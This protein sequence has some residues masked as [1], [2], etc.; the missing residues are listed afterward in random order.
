MAVKT[1]D[2]QKTSEDS[3]KSQLASAYEDGIVG[4]GATPQPTRILEPVFY[5]KSND[6]EDSNNNP[7]YS[8]DQDPEADADLINKTRIQKVASFSLDKDEIARLSEFLDARSFEDFTSKGILH[9]IFYNAITEE[10]T[11]IVDLQVGTD[12]GN[13]AVAV[14]NAIIGEVKTEVKYSK[15][16]LNLLSTFLFQ[17]MLLENSLIKGQFLN[18]INRGIQRELGPFGGSRSFINHGGQIDG[19]VLEDYQYW[20]G[21]IFRYLGGTTGINTATTKDFFKTDLLSLIAGS[22]GGLDGMNDNSLKNALARK[23]ISAWI[24]QCSVAGAIACDFGISLDF[25]NRVF[26]TEDIVDKH[27]SMYTGTTPELIKTITPDPATM[28]KLYSL[29]YMFGGSTPST[30]QNIKAAPV[31]KQANGG[32]NPINTIFDRNYQSVNIYGMMD[33]CDN[34]VYLSTILSRELQLSNGAHRIQRMTQPGAD[35]ARMMLQMGSETNG[36]LRDLHFSGKRLGVHDD[37]GKTIAERIFAFNPEK[38]FP[39]GPTW[40]AAYEFVASDD[41][42]ADIGGNHPDVGL[43]NTL[44]HLDPLNSAPV[45]DGMMTG[46]VKNFYAFE[47]T[48]GLEEKMTSQMRIGSNGTTITS[49][50]K[51]NLDDPF[52][53]GTLLEALKKPYDNL[54][55]AHFRLQQTADALC[56]VPEDIARFDSGDGQHQHEYLGPLDIMK[57]VLN[58]CAEMIQDVGAAGYHTSADPPTGLSKAVQLQALADIVCMTQFYRTQKDVD[59]TPDGSPTPS[60]HRQMRQYILRRFCEYDVMWDAQSRVSEETQGLSDGQSEVEEYYEVTGLKPSIQDQLSSTEKNAVLG[61]DKGF[62]DACNLVFLRWTPTPTGVGTVTFNSNSHTYTAAQYFEY[63]KSRYDDTLNWYDLVRVYPDFIHMGNKQN[64]LSYAP[65]I[66]GKGALVGGDQIFKLFFG[67]YADTL[68]GSIVERVRRVADDIERHMTK[69]YPLETGSSDDILNYGGTT[70]AHGMDR[71]Q[72]FSIILEMFSLVLCDMVETEFIINSSASR[73]QHSPDE[74]WSEDATLEIKRQYWFTSMSSLPD[75]GPNLGFDNPFEQQDDIARAHYVTVRPKIG[76]EPPERNF[77]PQHTG[78]DELYVD[79]SGFPLPSDDTPSDTDDSD[80]GLVPGLSSE[81]DPENFINPAADPYT[82]PHG[83]TALP[84]LTLGELGHYLS[85]INSQ[86]TVSNGSRIFP[87][88]WGGF[89]HGSLG[90]LEFQFSP[91]PFIGSKAEELELGMDEDFKVGGEMSLRTFQELGYKIREQS[92]AMSMSFYPLILMYDYVN[93]ISMLM[94]MQRLNQELRSN[95]VTEKGGYF[96]D[97]LDTFNEDLQ[98]LVE[99][100]GTDS[101]EAV[102][103]RIR[104]FMKTATFHQMDSV[105]E[106]IRDIET[107][108]EPPKVSA[109][110]N[111]HDVRTGIGTYRNNL[112]LDVAT[113]LMLDDMQADLENKEVETGVKESKHDVIFYGFPPDLLD[114]NMRALMASSLNKFYDP[115]VSSILRLRYSKTSE[116]DSSRFF[117][118]EPDQFDYQAINTSYIVTRGAIVRALNVHNS[119]TFDELVEDVKYR[120]VGQMLFGQSNSSGTFWPNIVDLFADGDGYK[121]HNLIEGLIGGL[122]P[123]P[124]EH[125]RNAVKSTLLQYLFERSSRMVGSDIMCSPGYSGKY[126]DKFYVKKIL[127]TVLNR[128]ATNRLILKMPNGGEDVPETFVDAIGVHGV[129]PPDLDD[130]IEAIFEPDTSPGALASSAREPVRLKRDF[131]EF[132]EATKPTIVRSGPVPLLKTPVMNEEMFIVIQALMNSSLASPRTIESEVFAPLMFDHVFAFATS[133]LRD[134][135]NFTEFVVDTNTGGLLSSAL[136]TSEEALEIEAIK[137]V[138]FQDVSLYGES[139]GGAF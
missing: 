22:I 6:P 39:N 25:V 106:K 57:K 78:A 68:S 89:Y 113:K 125:L 71:A 108:L 16:L 99:T 48:S 90:E 58:H 131:Q 70:M 86:Y 54:F 32:M 5:I 8:A 134:V 119:Q 56:H 66:T 28:T 62:I 107:G 122:D 47:S 77:I 29:E 79:P 129:N 37:A 82:G 117:V 94:G 10:N 49:I 85:R 43:M 118:Q 80:P 126:I 59:S 31:S 76:P 27:I 93:S 13:F 104:K 137:A 51:N 35:Q 30:P 92:C 72:L 132:L 128:S 3:V 50:I 7:A 138:F 130:L 4:Q 2:I 15:S 45:V 83:A 33:T 139:Y 17:R 123:I 67:L 69:R 114:S 26:E 100:S 95:S 124:R 74:M 52:E 64:A 9:Q 133:K 23:T 12:G 42:G 88:A 63:T 91:S 103:E 97:F 84:T 53:L 111:E 38:V 135:G 41:A 1:S 136:Q 46:P 44:L 127:R 116:L 81:E 11:D 121:G 24:G 120:S 19:L 75:P 34:L 87:D 101:V 14:L 102:R 65:P 61:Y 110:S 21:P 40:G 109:S 36:H 112:S 98:A 18:T 73:E 96:T 115:K 20:D 105:I 55:K 60:L